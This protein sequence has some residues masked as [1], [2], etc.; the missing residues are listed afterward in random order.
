MTEAQTPSEKCQSC[1]QVNPTSLKL[2]G[3]CGNV[4]P[5]VLQQRAAEAAAQQS[6][7]TQKKPKGSP[8]SAQGVQQAPTGQGTTSPLWK[9]LPKYQGAETP[10]ISL[11]NIE[12]PLSPVAALT[13]FVLLVLSPFVPLLNAVITNVNL[14]TSSPWLGW[15]NLIAA[16][17]VGMA[18]AQQGLRWC[19][20]SFLLSATSLAFFVLKMGQFPIE[21]VNPWRMVQW[22]FV[23][24]VLGPIACFV[25]AFFIGEPAVE[26]TEAANPFGHDEGRI[27]QNR[28]Y[29]RLKELSQTRAFQEAIR[30][31]TEGVKAQLHQLRSAT[32]W[33]EVAPETRQ[34]LE[35]AEKELDSSWELPTSPALAPSMASESASAPKWVWGAA[36]LIPLAIVAFWMFGPKPKPVDVELGLLDRYSW[37]SKIATDL[38]VGLLAELKSIEKQNPNAPFYILSGEMFILKNKPTKAYGVLSY[39]KSGKKIELNL[40]MDGGDLKI[41]PITLAEDVEPGNVGDV[42]TRYQDQMRLDIER[43]EVKRSS[44]AVNRSMRNLDSQFDNLKNSFP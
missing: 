29:L 39:D 44:D 28:I 31:D 38:A 26:Y 18:L 27:F 42:L 3:L 25:A 13:G 9:R 40:D 16:G 1:G 35:R 32:S 5:W 4:L 43:K 14:I 20:L 24:L 21:S 8:S 34:L 12:L 33:A 7:T 17:I 15:S 41:D 19:Y 11:G 2:C 37:K 6:K 22:G 23:P 36:G 10:L 30:A